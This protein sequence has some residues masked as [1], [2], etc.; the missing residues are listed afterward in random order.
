MVGVRETER[1]R[2]RERERECYV[3]GWLGS[4]PS[5]SPLVRE[6]DWDIEPPLNPHPLCSF[7]LSLFLSVGRQSTRKPL[8]LPWMKPLYVGALDYITLIDRYFQGS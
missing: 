4:L 3:V 1:E 6:G 2:E 8:V 7:S 5:S